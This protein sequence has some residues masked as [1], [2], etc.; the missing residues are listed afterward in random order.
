MPADDGRCLASEATF[1][2]VLRDEGQAAHRSYAKKPHAVR[3]STTHVATAPR[4]VWCWEMTYLPATVIGV[5]FH[6]Y[7]I[8]VVGPKRL[9][10]K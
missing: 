4:K 7:L 3:P 9:T 6:P 8:L 10:L 2:R 5:R 1:S